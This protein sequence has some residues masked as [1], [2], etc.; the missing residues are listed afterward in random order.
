MNSMVFF[1]VLLSTLMAITFG[2][3]A[4]FWTSC[5]EF[6][7]GVSCGAGNYEMFRQSC[8]NWFCRNFANCKQGFC[9]MGNRKCG[10]DICVPNGC[11]EGC[12]KCS[13]GKH[14]ISEIGGQSCTVY[15]NGMAFEGTRN[16]C[17]LDKP[18]CNKHEKCL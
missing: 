16:F 17:C 14:L 12:Q 13:P 18:A 6:N 10:H 8:G 9:C 2:D 11:K 3:S 7:V 5:N 1:L 4:C 15:F